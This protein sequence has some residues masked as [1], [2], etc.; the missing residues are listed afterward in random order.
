[1]TTRN[2]PDWLRAYLDFTAP[3]ESPTTF[4][5]WTGVVTIAGALRRRV[6]ID[7]RL[8]Q[9]TP[10][11]YVVLVGP[12]GV[13]AKSTSMR[14][15]FRLLKK[16]PGIHFGPDSLTWQ[17]LIESFREAMVMVPYGED[18][19]P[20]SCITCGVSELGTFLRP[21]DS[22]LVNVLVDM[23]DGQV[24]AWSRATKAEGQR[25]IENPWINA[26]GCTTPA[27]FSSNFTEDMIGGGL[28]SR[29]V[30]VYGE[31]KRQLVP[32]PS[33]V[34]P[35]S[36]FEEMEKKLVDDLAIIS[37]LIG[38]YELTPDARAWGAVWYEEHWASRPI[39][40]ASERYGG[41]LA[42]KQT[43]IHKLAM[44]LAASQRNELIIEQDDLETANRFVTS[45]ETD[46]SKVFESIGQSINNR[47][48]GE[49]LA[50]VRAYKGIA[51]R[52]LWRK[53]MKIMSPREFDEAITAA[54]QANFIRI[55]QDETGVSYLPWDMD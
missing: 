6:W 37:E 34:V 54:I 27:W 43:H 11:F 44:V 17:A 52:E 46:M 48:V 33:Q 51:R 38:P 50:F 21:D 47:H 20:M 36:D 23:W 39:H 13:A 7:E 16:I 12:P 31:E 32:Y 2:F 49:M 55:H 24:N 29:I 14:V 10:N 1:M 40:M 53:C 18:L 35:R 45:L 8:F 22:D 42:R 5:F 3:S 19:F 41:Y 25:F 9:W 28:T 15:G 4:H 26:I 30:F